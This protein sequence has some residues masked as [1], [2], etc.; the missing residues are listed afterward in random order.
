MWL[1]LL[2]AVT[3][4]VLCSIMFCGKKK[5]ATQS[6]E[7]V[8]KPEEKSQETMEKPTA[9]EKKSAELNKLQPQSATSFSR[10]TPTPAAAPPPPP[11]PPPAAP[12]PP[13]PPPANAPPAPPA[14]VPLPVPEGGDDVG[15]EM[16]PDMTP[17]E[18]A[19]VIPK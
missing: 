1:Q 7:R 14:P 18:L 9:E 19:K 2:T 3:I 11:P 13:P 12:P 8:Q 4:A 6:A 15:Y 10:S 5:K 16:C 17:E